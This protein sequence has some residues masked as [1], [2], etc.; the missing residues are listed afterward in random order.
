M[1]QSVKACVYRFLFCSNLYLTII[2]WATGVQSRET[3]TSLYWTPIEW[4][5]WCPLLTHPHSFNSSTSNFKSPPSHWPLCLILLM[6]LKVQSS[7]MYLSEIPFHWVSMKL[8]LQPHCCL[9]YDLFK[10][11]SV[12]LSLRWKIE[13][14]KLN[15]LSFRSI[16]VRSLF[17]A[18]AK[19]KLNI[20]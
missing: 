2:L 3:V 20:G 17:S 14:L 11:I 1:L 16:S 10:F 8:S 19:Q 15:N 7:Y 9:N 4:R 5:Q 13:K 12:A 6:L 18:L